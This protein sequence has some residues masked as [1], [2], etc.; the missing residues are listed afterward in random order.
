V[1]ARGGGK[2]SKEEFVASA[3]DYV[4]TTRMNHW[5][6]NTTKTNQP[7]TELKQ[8]NETM[9]VKANTTGKNMN[10][11][12]AELKQVIETESDNANITDETYKPPCQVKV[13]NS[14][15]S[16]FEVIESVARQF[17]LKY[18][19]LPPECDHSNLFFDLS[20][21]SDKKRSQSF[22]LYMNDHVLNSTNAVSIDTSLG[23]PVKR[24]IQHATTDDLN[25]R[26]YHAKIQ[27][28]CYCNHRKVAWLHD[29]LKGDQYHH[30]IFHER[31]DKFLDFPRALWVSPHFPRHFIPSSLPQPPAQKDNSTDVVTICSV[32]STNRREFTLLARFLE[33]NSENS[34][35]LSKIRL[36][37]LGGSSLPNVLKPFWEMLHEVQHVNTRNDWL[38]AA[39]VK[40]CDVITLM[41]L[42][43]KHGAYFPSSGN[44]TSLSKLSGTM[45][46]IIAYHKSFVI[47]QEMINLYEPYLPL[48]MP[49]VGYDE[50]DREP[51]LGAFYSLLTT[52]LENKEKMY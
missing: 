39:S 38:F 41:I 13:R 5:S 25:N 49:H 48:D 8:V 52:T 24:T 19:Q 29:W 36:Q 42:K 12:P 17:P 6:D 22:L 23:T 40:G 50:N 20:T 35:L 4:N 14:V 16:H 33:K 47:P 44:F 7:P 1:L 26:Q 27:V 3:S 30:C 10:E 15:M 21:A 2:Q 43:E 45:P 31:C 9:S 51:F 46:A 37:F 28:S 34:E 32:G 18:L 11:P